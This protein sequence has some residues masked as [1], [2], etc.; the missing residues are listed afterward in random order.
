[1][2]HSSICLLIQKGYMKILLSFICFLIYEA[3][4]SQSGHLSLVTAETPFLLLFVLFLTWSLPLKKTS[5]EMHFS[6][7]AAPSFSSVAV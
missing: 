6:P 3:I 1:M 2:T 4:C 5:Y 7:T